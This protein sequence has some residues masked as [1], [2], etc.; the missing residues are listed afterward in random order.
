MWMDEN[1]VFEEVEFVFVMDGGKN[2]YSRVPTMQT[3]SEE[4]FV[5]LSGPTEKSET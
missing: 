1:S 4:D 3:T 2:V 5:T